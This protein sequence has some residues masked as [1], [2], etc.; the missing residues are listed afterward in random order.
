MGLKKVEGPYIANGRR[1]VTVV[2][3]G[4][5]KYKSFARAKYC[6]VLKTTLDGLV[7]DHKD[8]NPLNDALENLEPVTYSENNRRAFVLGLKKPSEISSE[9]RSKAQKGSLNGMALL[10]SEQV[11]KYRKLFHSGS[12]SQEDIIQR[13]GLS[14]RAVSNMLYGESYKNV[15]LPEVLRAKNSVGRKKRG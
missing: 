13:S 6:S 7:I 4:Y 3:N 11:L 1:Y 14:R 5:R 12:L 10:T 9:T 15:E 2:V 8:G